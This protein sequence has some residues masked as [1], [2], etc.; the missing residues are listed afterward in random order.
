MLQA[1]LRTDADLESF[2]LDYF[3]D[4]QRRFSKSMDRVAQTNCLL[5][6]EDPSDVLAKLKSHF[7]DDLSAQVEIDHLL[8]LPCTDEERQRRELFDTLE[9]FYEERGRLQEQ[10]LSTSEIDGQIVRIKRTLRQVAE[11]M[12]GAILDGRYRLIESIGRG[13]FARV[14][15]AFDRRSQRFVAVKILHRQQGDER[16]RVERFQRGARQMQGLN[17]P[18]IVRVLD[19]PYEENGAHYFVMDYLPAG[20]LYRAILH[21]KIER[22]DALQAILQ[23]GDALDY[24]N[25]RGLVHRDVK[26]QNILIDENG[27]A[28]LADFD[29]V[30]AQDSTGGTRTTGMGTFL[31]AAPEEMEDA[32]RVDERADVYSLAM[33]TIFVLYGRSLPRRVVDTRRSF[34]GSLDCNQA[35]KDLLLQ[36]TA[37]EPSARPG[38]AWA[39]CRALLDALT[40]R[41]E[42]TQ[43]AM[44]EARSPS[45]ITPAYALGTSGA[46]RNSQRYISVACTLLLVAAGLVG[47]RLK[48]KYVHTDTQSER[49]QTLTTGISANPHPPVSA[50]I[51]KP[52]PPDSIAFVVHNS[53]ILDGKNVNTGVL[54]Q[55]PTKSASRPKRLVFCGKY[56]KACEAYKIRD[57][58]RLIDILVKEPSFHNDKILGLTY[59]IYENTHHAVANERNF[60]EWALYYYKIAANIDKK[61]D[62]M[63]ADLFSNKI[64]NI[65][66]LISQ[67][68]NDMKATGLLREAQDLYLK[69]PPK[70]RLACRRAIAALSNSPNHPVAKAANN[71]L[72]LIRGGTSAD[73]EDF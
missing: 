73:D 24:A 34:I 3:P 25:R 57:F 20:D 54:P 43:S 7:A 16:R 35:T 2:C 14:W 61:L 63:H 6:T 19:G 39:F 15:R 31:F 71:L 48:R 40:E 41:H 27:D 8:S 36:A 21:K 59:K 18:H 12:E 55:E 10:R 66:E 23:I 65:Q 38:T 42:D 68:H 29:L 62:G 50:A 33:T 45:V 37:W 4:V 32:S 26:P 5:E 70:A 28:R 64:M 60:P 67:N 49:N 9:T 72:R 58:S 1:L 56:R 44:P 17:H 47:T 69:D 13:G 30:W 22:Q 52:D 46:P 11:V 53:T 51:H